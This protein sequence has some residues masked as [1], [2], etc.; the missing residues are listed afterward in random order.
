MVSLKIAVKDNKLIK[1]RDTLMIEDAINSI[2]CS[3]EFRSDWS[4]L[5]KTVVFARGHIFPATQNPETISVSLDANNEC[6]VPQEIISENGQFSIG[7]FGESEGT[8]VVT[9]WLYYKT[10]LGCYDV[11]IV[12]NPPTPSVYDKILTDLNNKSDID[13]THSE[14]IT[15]EESDTF[16]EEKVSQTIDEILETSFDAGKIIER[17]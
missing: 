2:K 17:S 15:L 14:Y 6:M 12:P 13:H 8:R 3:F 7:L 10:Q 4:N 16:I 9:N 5:Q 11:G 1:V